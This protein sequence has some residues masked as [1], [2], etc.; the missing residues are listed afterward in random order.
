MYLP[1]LL[2]SLKNRFGTPSSNLGNGVSVLL[3]VNAFEKGINSFFSLLAV[4]QIVGKIYC[5]TVT[6]KTIYCIGYG[7][8]LDILEFGECELFPQ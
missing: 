5:L 7:T 4:S 6:Y 2:S 1:K 8:K 3:C